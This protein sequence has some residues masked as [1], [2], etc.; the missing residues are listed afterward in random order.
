MACYEASK[1]FLDETLSTGGDE[2]SGY[3][4]LALSAT[5]AGS[6]DVIH[7]S[8][9]TADIFDEIWVYVNNTNN[10]ALDVTF[11]IAENDG[12]NDV[13]LLTITIPSKSGLTCV[14]AGLVLSGG[15][16]LE[17]FAPSNP[18]SINVFGFV[19]RVDQTP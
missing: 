7:T 12:A 15:Y 13:E 2:S 9:S 8:S 14:I 3:A 19:N 1:L 6:P 17:A 11:Q 4:G 5:T 16:R 18:S 10:S